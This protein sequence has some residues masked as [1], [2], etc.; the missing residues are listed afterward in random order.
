MACGRCF[1]QQAV[2]GAPAGKSATTNAPAVSSP[3]LSAAEALFAQGKYSDAEAAAN[4]LSDGDK[5]SV[6]GNLLRGRLALSANQLSAAQGLF[7]Q[8]L[9][10]DVK[11]TI[12]AALLGEVYARQQLWM[13][14]APQYDHGRRNALA[15]Q[16][17]DVA[18]SIP[19]A[20]FRVDGLG[21]LDRIPLLSAQPPAVLGVRVGA[22]EIVNFAIDLS[23]D[24]LTIDTAYAKQLELK[25]IGD[26][27]QLLREAVRPD[28]TKLDRVT[29]STIP[30]FA[31]G[32]WTVRDLP[33]TVRSLSGNSGAVGLIGAGVLRHFLVTLDVPHGQIWLR[34]P[35]DASAAAARKQAQASAVKTVPVRFTPAG[36]LVHADGAPLED[37]LWRQ[38]AVTMDFKDMLLYIGK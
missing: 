26:L 20:P 15:L 16:A 29:Y 18:A 8:A 4:K 13:D 30:E 31:I 35:G 1:A 19:Y 17:Q 12:A 24:Q 9:R 7:A 11:N 2:T 21:A 38:G 27:D 14:A 25:T 28:G 34:R 32:V 22:G 37:T 3:A 5:Y 6:A 33:V 23:A 10:L 36:A